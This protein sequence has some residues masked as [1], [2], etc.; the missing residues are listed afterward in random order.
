MKIEWLTEDEINQLGADL[1]ANVDN[2][3]PLY[4]GVSKLCDMA[5]AALQAKPTPT[6]DLKDSHAVHVNMM[7]GEIGKL[8]PAQVAHLYSAEECAAI[9]AE[10]QRQHPTPTAGDVREAALDLA[11]CADNVNSYALHDYQVPFHAATMMAKAAK[12]VRAAIRATET[13]KPQ[14]EEVPPTQS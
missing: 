5:L 8:T 1:Q 4:V 2:S 10:I 11:N 12:K 7:R 9:V 13:A 14:G 6:A 3:L